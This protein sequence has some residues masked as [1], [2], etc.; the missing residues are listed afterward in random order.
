M[1]SDILCVNLRGAN[2]AFAVMVTGVR[3]NT[4]P[5]GDSVSRSY[6]AAAA[7]GEGGRLLSGLGAVGGVGG[8]DEQ[9]LVARR[10]IAV[11]EDLR[12]APF[13]W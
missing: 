6:V 1:E 13:S 8:V 5:R 4:K 10:A 9:D 7:V 3:G 11:G 12:V 2:G